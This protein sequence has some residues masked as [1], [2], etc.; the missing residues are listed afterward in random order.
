MEHAYF[1]ER[2][3]ALG[4]QDYPALQQLIMKHQRNGKSIYFSFVIVVTVVVVVVVD[5]YF[6]LLYIDD[7]CALYVLVFLLDRSSNRKK[8]FSV[9]RDGATSYLLQNVPVSSVF[10]IDSFGNYVTSHENEAI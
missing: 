8:E 2:I 9:T 3:I 10:L 4:K 1:R 6:C 5:D 7:L